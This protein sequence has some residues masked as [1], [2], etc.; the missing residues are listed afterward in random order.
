[1]KAGFEDLKIWQEAHRLMLKVHEIA[2][3]LPKSVEFEKILQSKRSSSS[4][5]DNIAEGYSSYYYNE[6]IKGMRIARKETGETQNHI[7]AIAARGY[8]SKELEEELVSRYQGLIMGINAYTKYI[9]EKR[10]QEKKKKI[11]PVP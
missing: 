8:I 4:V 3:K 1:M 7:K 11:N 9:C 2:N 5:A 10:D 6:K